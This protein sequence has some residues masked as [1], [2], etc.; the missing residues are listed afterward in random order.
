M[1]HWVPQ[2]WIQ[3]TE[4]VGHDNSCIEVCT[5]GLQSLLDSLYISVVF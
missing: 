1:V 2:E 4:N 3:G 5:S